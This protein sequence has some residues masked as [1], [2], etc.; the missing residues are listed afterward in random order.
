MELSEICK[1]LL[2]IKDDV[3]KIQQLQKE[4]SLV[5]EEGKVAILA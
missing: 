5:V 1:P 4:G 3:E 2:L